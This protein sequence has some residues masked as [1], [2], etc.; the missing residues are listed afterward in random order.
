M[1]NHVNRYLILIAALCAG[2]AQAQIDTTIP[3]TE[4][5]LAKPIEIAPTAPGW[6]RTGTGVT[7]PG[8]LRFEE[9]LR[10]IDIAPAP[11]QVPFVLSE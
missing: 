6:M 7:L 11:A 5:A 9:Y 3:Y 8:K 4:V 2:A 1:G 10:P